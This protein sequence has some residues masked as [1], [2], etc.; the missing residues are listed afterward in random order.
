MN[1]KTEQEPFW[2]GEFGDRYIDRNTIK[3]MLPARLALF[4]RILARTHAV[5]VTYSPWVT[6]MASP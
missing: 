2:A 6:G 3:E 4:S 1:Y 5:R